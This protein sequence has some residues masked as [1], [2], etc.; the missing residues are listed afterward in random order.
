MLTNTAPVGAYRGAGRPEAIYIIERLM[1]EAARQ[2]GIDRI[3]LRR[4]NFIR[5]EQMPYKN[6]MA[7]VYDDGKF[8]HVMDQALALADWDGFAAR[9]AASKQQR[10]V[11]AAW[12]SRPSWN[13]PAATC[14]RNASR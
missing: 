13:G 9:E 5:P 14:S 1:D 12:A 2:T 8:E 10:P 11:G 6:P 7:Q 3:A 4:R